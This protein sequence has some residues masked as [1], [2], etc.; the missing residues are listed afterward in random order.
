MA[1][2]RLYFLW[3]I[4]AALLLTVIVYLYYEKRMQALEHKSFT[5]PP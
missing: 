5:Q 1:K 2:K 4:I 3:I